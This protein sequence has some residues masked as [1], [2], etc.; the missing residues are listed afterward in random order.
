MILILMAMGEKGITGHK[1]PS[2]KV[3]G[4]TIQNLIPSIS[5]FVGIISDDQYRVIEKIR[6]M[7]PLLDSIK[8]QWGLEENQSIDALYNS[9]E[10]ENK[11]ECGELYADRVL[12]RS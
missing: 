6:R 11:L 10:T 5:N 3:V 1:K 7:M 12:S 2:I 9:T 8:E 4:R